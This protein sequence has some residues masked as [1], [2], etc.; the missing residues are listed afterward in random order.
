MKNNSEVLG[1]PRR[2]KYVIAG[3]K[4]GMIL[5]DGWTTERQARQYEFDFD[6]EPEITLG[7]EDEYIIERNKEFPTLSLDDCEYMYTGSEFCTRLLAFDGFM[8]HASAVVVGDKAYLFSAPSGTGKSTHTSLW[9]ETFKKDGAYI[10]NDDKPVL[11]LID[12]EVRTF[13]TPW[14]GKNDQSRNANVRLGGICFLERSEENWIKELSKKD[15][16][17]RILDQTIRPQ[18]EKEM[19]DLLDV[20]DRCLENIKIWNMGCNISK[21]AAKMAFDTMKGE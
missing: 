12:G 2:C 15:A 16:L 1:V 5:R 11:R 3:I 6:G 13:G 8:L 21:D 20:L 9:L 10:L 14:S 17:Y 7:L 4:T 18:N 19:T